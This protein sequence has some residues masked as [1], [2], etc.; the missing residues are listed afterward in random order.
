[1][2]YMNRYKKWITTCSFLFIFMLLSVTLAGDVG[3]QSQ[4]CVSCASGS[5]CSGMC[6]TYYIPGD[7][8]D[9]NSSDCVCWCTVCW[10]DSNGAPACVQHW[11]NCWN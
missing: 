10:I 6:C 11:M 4:G 1:M 9:C 8:V 3:G 5:F 2:V 7:V